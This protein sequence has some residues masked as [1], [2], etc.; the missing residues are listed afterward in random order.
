M[1]HF[2]ILPILTSKASRH[3]PP[4]QL[5]C[6]TTAKCVDI[7]RFCNGV[8]DCADGSDEASTCC[9][10]TLFSPDFS[11][12]FKHIFFVLLL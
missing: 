10:T 8:Q 9:T 4:N 5:A 2:F 6:N 7:E 1:H 3:C 11:K 12:H